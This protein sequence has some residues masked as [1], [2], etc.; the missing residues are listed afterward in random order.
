M[1]WQTKKLSDVCEII[2]GQS[3]PSSDYNT[4]GEGMPF[5]QGKAEF[6][7]LYPTTV[8]YCT[9]PKKIAEPED[10]LLSVRAPV[11]PTNLAPSRACIGRGLAAIR[12]KNRQNQK[13][14]LHFFRHIE[15]WL[16][17]TG[18][19]STFTAISK[20]DV[21]EIEIPLPPLSEQRRIADKLDILL[22]KV[23][24]CKSR[25][26]RIPEILK[27]FRQSVL[28]DACSGKLTEDWREENGVSLKASNVEAGKIVSDEPYELPESWAWVYV[29]DI[30]DVQGGIQKQPKRKP[31]KNRYP[32]LRV[33][34]VLRGRLDLAE[35]HEVEL[36]AGELERF[37]LVKGDVLVVE[38]NGSFS[39]IGRS[40]IWDGSIKD[41]VHQNHIIRV[42]PVKCHP[43]YFDYY[44]NSLPAIS[45]ITSVSVTTSGLYSLSTKKVKGIPVPL[46]P[47]AEQSVIVKTVDRLF[48]MADSIESR[49]AKVKAPVE[50]LSQA[51]LSKAFRGEL[52]NGAAE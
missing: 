40:A 11:G 49:F 32:F 23:N 46:P 28:A 34:N 3:P 21:H 37:R 17:K 30:A 48:S 45:L 20:K 12:F 19:G 8:K 51:I 7:E 47:M 27:R 43:R 14:L 2:M 22:A 13:Y 39:E 26:E 16:S 5:F 50:Q 18:T 33:A 25:L 41:C 1:S 9:A 52:L 31:L 24:K 35:I 38:G 6:G 36:F 42:R 44:W 4:T 10:I 15:P 29:D